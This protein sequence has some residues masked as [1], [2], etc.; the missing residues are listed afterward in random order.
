MSLYICMNGRGRT[1]SGIFNCISTSNVNNAE[2]FSTE[3]R[4]VVIDAEPRV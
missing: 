1:I 4:L 2:L 3:P